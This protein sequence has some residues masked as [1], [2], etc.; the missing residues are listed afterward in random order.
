MPKPPLS[1][2]VRKKQGVK[3]AGEWVLSGDKEDLIKSGLD[4][5]PKY[6][7]NKSKGIVR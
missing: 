4:I 7:S 1:K 5:R 6:E 2:L 3:G